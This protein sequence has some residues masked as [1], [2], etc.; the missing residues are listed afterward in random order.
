[1]TG[2]SAAPRLKQHNRVISDRLCAMT[3]R[4]AL[5]LLPISLSLAMLAQ[6]NGPKP[7]KVDIPGTTLNRIL[8]RV[9]SARLPDG[10]NAP[11]WR[12][13]ANWEYMKSLTEYWAS[14]FDWKKAE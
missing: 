2:F 14:R 9:K 4:D 3:R 10:L 12:Y 5:R 1:M 11:D 7:F 6:N 13:G 8:T